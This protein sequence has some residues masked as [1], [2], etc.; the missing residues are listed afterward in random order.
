MSGWN[1]QALVSEAS[2]NLAAQPGRTVILLAIA[3]GG[4]LSVSLAELYTATGVENR[5]RSLIAQ[6]YTTV[7]VV[8]DPGGIPARDCAR[9]QGQQGVLAAGGVGTVSTVFAGSSPGLGFWEARSAGNVVGALTGI[10]HHGGPPGLFLSTELA[11][12]LGVRAGSYLNIGGRPE[13]VAGVFPFGQRDGLLGRIV[14]IPSAPAG[15]LQACYVQFAA[16]DYNAGA[17]ALSGVFGGLTNVTIEGLLPRGPGATSPATSWNRRSTRFGWLAAGLVLAAVGLLTARSRYHELSVYV[18]TGSWRS[19]VAAM[20]LCEAAL[21]LGLAAISSIAWTSF[22]TVLVHAGW[23]PF[24][25]A[26]VGLSRTMLV[27]AA[28]TPLG[29]VPLFRRDLARLLRERA[30]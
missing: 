23:E 24:H 26:L 11:S 8:A 1:G 5:N 25:A 13:R 14:L 18:L 29:L 22:L 19:E 7:K 17:T 30:S 9:L 10:V 15:R 12:Q 2:K 16:G 21:I 6:G 4:L 27:A 3:L 28:M 20:Y